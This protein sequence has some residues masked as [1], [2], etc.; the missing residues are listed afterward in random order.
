MNFYNRARQVRD[1]T[2]RKRRHQRRTDPQR[3]KEL[4]EALFKL[5]LCIIIMIVSSTVPQ[6]WATTSVIILTQV[7]LYMHQNSMANP[8]V[9]IDLI[10]HNTCLASQYCRN[11]ASGSRHTHLNT[12]NSDHYRQATTV[13]HSTNLSEV[14][15][16]VSGSLCLLDLIIQTVISY[17]T[18]LV[19]M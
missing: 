3:H 14:R 18:L 15:E 7:K 6:D 2:R 11:K 19:I 16:G 4:V 13:I 10:D 8:L 5:A 1:I 9:A 12:L 17:L